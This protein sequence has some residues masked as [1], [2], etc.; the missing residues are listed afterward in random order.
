MSCEGREESSTANDLGQF[1]ACVQ[2]D[3][4][5]QKLG[6]ISAALFVAEGEGNS[7]QVM[8]CKDRDVQSLL[9]STAAEVVRLEE[10]GNIEWKYHTT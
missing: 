2:T 10:T 5:Q 4:V 6:D 7:P 9:H 1:R 8:A 3:E